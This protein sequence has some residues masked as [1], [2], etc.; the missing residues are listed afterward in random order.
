MHINLFK[1]L[2]ISPNGYQSSTVPIHNHLTPAYTK[3][4]HARKQYTAWTIRSI[5]KLTRFNL[6][7]LR[8][9]WEYIRGP[10]GLGLHFC[11]VLLQ[12]RI[13]WAI[14]ARAQRSGGVERDGQPGGRAR[15]RAALRRAA[16]RVAGRGAGR[17]AR[18]QAPGR[19]GWLPQDWGDRA[20]DRNYQF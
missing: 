8:V 19:R 17:G 5:K 7:A 11:I 12:E 16:R 14:V 6:R 13:G 18:R 2:S 4:H 3:A 15:D 10:P 20:W 1:R 9:R